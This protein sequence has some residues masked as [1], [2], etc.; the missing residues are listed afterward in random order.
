MTVDKLMQTK[1]TDVIG[2]IAASVTNKQT[3]A[4]WTGN[5]DFDFSR[6]TVADLMQFAMADRKITWANANRKHI[7]DYRARKSVTVAVPPPG[8]RDHVGRVITDA[9]AI[10][11]V[12]VSMDRDTA[13]AMINAEFDRRNTDDA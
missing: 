1:L 4:N 7:D 10:E 3:N 9:T 5:I 13:L 2:R 11:H 12:A 6:C 8:T